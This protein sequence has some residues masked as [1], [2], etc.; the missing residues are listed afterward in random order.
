MSTEFRNPGGIVV[1]AGVEISGGNLLLS[2]GTGYI[3]LYKGE[4]RNARVQNLAADPGSPVTGQIYYNTGNNTL[5]FYDGSNF[6]TLTTGSGMTFGSPTGLTVGGSN[7]DGVGTNAARNDHVHSLPNWG[8]VTAETSFGGSSGNGS[9]STFAR[10]DHTHGNPTAPTASSVGAVA[11]GAN[12]PSIYADVTGS[13]PA[14]GTAGRIFIDTTTARLQRDTGAAWVDLMAF[15]APSASAVGDAQG[16]GTANTYAR[17]DHVHA[18]EA[19]GAVTAQTSYGSASGNGSAA[20]VAR[21]D[22]THGTVS[23]SSNVASAQTPGD[24]AT[25]GTGTAPAKD[26]HKHSLPAWG[27]TAAMAAVAAFGAANAQGSAATFAR[28]D[29]AHG[30]PAHDGAAHSAISISS[31]AVPSADV[32]WNSKK[33][34][35]LLDPTGAQDAATKAY[36]DSIASGLDD[37]KNSVRVATT[38]AGTLASSFANGQ[39][40]DGVTLATGDRI[41]IKNQASA[42]ENGIYIVASSGA[43]TRATDA[44]ASGELSVGTLVYVETGT[45]NGAQ[46]WVCSATGATPWVPNS[47]TSTWVMFFAVTSTQAG[48]GLTATGNVLAVGAGTGITVNADSVQIDTSWVGQAAITTVG[49]ITTGTW[50]ATDVAVAAGGTGSSTAAGA[51]TNLGAAGVYVLS[52]HAASTPITV[53]HALG[54]Q[55]VNVS[56]YE[57]ATGKL[58]YADVTATDANNCSV[59]FASAPTLNQYRIVVTG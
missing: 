44:D 30:L 59:A 51:R 10:S 41:L 8:A 26:D 32:A 15:A 50:N 6:V 3:D 20:T 27:L 56:V 43:P 40:V 33:I 1:A 42:S 13:R 38:A 49:T 18:R 5:R 36:V 25:N 28:I 17:S 9:A 2:A 19:F 34:T 57:Q 45:A 39:S 12:T 35:G 23:L 55:Y 54:Q 58:V 29:H 24:T 47:S 21:S 4:L 37:F 16:A 48:N 22:H 7:S 46:Q 52:S 11:N 31:L 14:F 53:N